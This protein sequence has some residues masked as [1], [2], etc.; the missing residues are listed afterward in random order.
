[1]KFLDIIPRF[2]IL[3]I[4]CLFSNEILGQ[5]VQTITHQKWVNN[6]W[7]NDNKENYIYDSNGFEIKN[8]QQ[9]WNSDSNS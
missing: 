4:I 9:N 1:M 6:S 8:F 7:L 2:F 5:N 3:T